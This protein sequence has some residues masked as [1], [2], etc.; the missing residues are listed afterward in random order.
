MQL[1]D[2]YSHANGK[3]ILYGGSVVL[4]FFYL[5]YW[6]LELDKVSFLQAG[7]GETQRDKI[8]CA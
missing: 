3:Q 8:M 6:S 1:S 2:F 4:R 5:V 7:T